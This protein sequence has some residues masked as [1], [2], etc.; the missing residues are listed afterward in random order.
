MDLAAVP[1]RKVCERTVVVVVVHY[2]ASAWMIRGGD[3][4]KPTTGNTRNWMGRRRRKRLPEPEETL[5]A[6]S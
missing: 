5:R 6:G 2:S 1:E 4:R 3:S